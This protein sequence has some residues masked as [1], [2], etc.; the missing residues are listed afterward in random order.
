MKIFTD[1]A[2][3]RTGT[4][5]PKKI[6]GLRLVKDVVKLTDEAY[7]DG[8]LGRT[9]KTNL[10]GKQLLTKCRTVLWCVKA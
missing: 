8:G 10:E 6:K 2:T 3:V 9:E 7:F 5:L 4:T 1:T